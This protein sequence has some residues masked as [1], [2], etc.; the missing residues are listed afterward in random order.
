MAADPPGK[1]PVS[2]RLKD[3]RPSQSPVEILARVVQSQRREYSRPADS[4]KRS[5]LSG[6]LSDGTATVRFVWWEPPAE[7]VERGVVLRATN[8]QVQEYQERPEL[9]FNFRT[10]VAPASD[11]ELP[12]VDS[13][14]VPFRTIAE[15]HEREEG[16][17]LEARVVRVA[18][19]KVTVGTEQRLV[20]EGL[21]A[22]ATGMIGFTSWSD[23]GLHPG[24]TIRIAGAYVRPFRRRPQMVLDEHSV[25]TRCEGAG[26]PPAE[27][28]LHPR[29][30]TVASLE[31][32]GGSELASVEGLVVGVL[33]PSGLVYR[34][35][36]C[37]RPVSGGLCATH[38]TVRGVADLRSRLVV[39]DG[40]AAV[41]VNAGREET[42]RLWGVTLEGALERLRRAPDASLL[43]S[44]LTEEVVGRRV[45]VTGRIFPDDFGLNLYP[46]SVESVP[47]DLGG[48]IER[49][50]PRLSGGSHGAP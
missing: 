35:P 7:G 47:V 25:I 13:E 14:E 18:E 46:E 34:C 12:P 10:R 39:D 50:R 45:R 17:R 23:F 16:F 49:L 8:V 11:A 21:L 27:G 4:R 30:Q 40:T 28:M 20:F 44:S 15:V 31:A 26:L 41:T 37:H 9:V 3:L 22:D 1:E 43:E 42:E 33:P 6:L 5:Y 2:V 24:E 32:Q 36:T 38:G 29:P 19:R 48:V